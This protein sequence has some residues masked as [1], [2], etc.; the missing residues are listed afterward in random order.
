MLTAKVDESNINS[1][2]DVEEGKKITFIATP[3]ENYKVKEWKVVTDVSTNVVQG[4][5][6]NTYEHTVGK[7]DAT[8]TI[9]FEL[10]PVEGGAVLILSAGKKNITLIAKT[11][12]GSKITVKGCTEKEL[13]SDNEK[14]L[15][16]DDKN[17]ANVIILKCKNEG[18]NII[19]LAC[20]G[21]FSVK[22]PL[23]ALNVQGLTKLQR[24]DCEFNQLAKLNV[25]GCVALK[26]L[27]CA[28]N[29]LT[30]L[31]VHGFTKLEEFSCEVNK[32]T[33]LGVEGCTALKSLQCYQNKLSAD[34]M[35]KLLTDLPTYQG[36]NNA[37]ATLYSEEEGNFKEFSTNEALKAAFQGAK[38]RNWTLQKID[39]T[40][41][42]VEIVLN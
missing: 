15:H 38:S 42:Y 32:L 13:N 27:L 30:S 25:Q 33:A 4:N 26:G 35:T 10:A 2:D 11:E 28:D 8:I 40:G 14:E 6:T 29:K 41:D 36:N 1:G 9:S 34:V 3:S 12:N 18:D 20:N 23:A 39:N 24:F 7:K 37:F 5:N 22:M 17:E 31:D 16:L 19:E 21:S